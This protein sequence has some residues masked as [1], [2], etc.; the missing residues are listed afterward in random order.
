MVE[1]CFHCKG[2]ISLR[3]RATYRFGEDQ[4]FSRNALSCFRALLEI[5]ALLEAFFALLWRR[6]AS[7]DCFGLALNYLLSMFLAFASGP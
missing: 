7:R 6:T 5:V 3:L 1:A 4:G 2:G